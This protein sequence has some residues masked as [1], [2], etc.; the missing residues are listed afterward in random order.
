MIENITYKRKL[1]EDGTPYLD[2]NGDYINEVV[3]VEQVEPDEFQL[4]EKEKLEKDK[5]FGKSLIDLFLIE[6]RQSSLTFTPSI[7]I[8]LL[9]KFDNIQ[10]LAEVGDIKTVK[11]LLELVIVDEIFTQERKYNYVQLCNKYLGL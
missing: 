11:Y 7:N 5:Q 8:G 2:E 4:S 3:S 1:N 6:N 9:Q 10:K